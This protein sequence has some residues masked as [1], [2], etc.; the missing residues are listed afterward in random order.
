M[1]EPKYRAVCRELH[2]LINALK[3]LNNEFTPG[4]L[5]GRRPPENRQRDEEDQS[6]FLF[7]RSTHLIKHLITRAFFTT[8]VLHG[9]CAP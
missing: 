7:D 3:L 2:L 4:H 1:R 8:P 9:P 5:Y 6:P